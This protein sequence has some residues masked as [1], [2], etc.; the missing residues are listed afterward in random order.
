MHTMIKIKLQKV[1]IKNILK[2][3]RDGTV[4]KDTCHSSGG[5]RFDFLHAHNSSKLSV[6]HYPE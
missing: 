5:P 6:T 4:A 3:W 1:V 2:D